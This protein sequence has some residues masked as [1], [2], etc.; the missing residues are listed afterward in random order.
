MNHKISSS[1]Q[2]P[3]TIY[4]KSTATSRRI[5]KQF[6][7]SIFIMLLMALSS[8][9]VHA[10]NLPAAGW[11][12]GDVSVAQENSA[13]AILAALQSEVPNIEVDVLDFID[14]TGTRVGL[15]AHDSEMERISGI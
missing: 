9:D 2:V 10:L 5:S 4:S 15:L 7:T 14:E 12:R 8:A 1:S 3:C 6:V 11:H 13:K